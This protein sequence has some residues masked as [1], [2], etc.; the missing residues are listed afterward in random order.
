M[1][2]VFHD[3]DDDDGL[4]GMCERGDVWRMEVTVGAGGR[5][6]QISARVL[7]TL[8]WAWPTRLSG[9]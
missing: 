6:L 9:S 8:L 3:D 1:R 7:Q 2:I 4:L 5:H